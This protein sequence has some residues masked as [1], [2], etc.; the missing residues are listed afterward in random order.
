M[1]VCTCGSVSL[2]VC[3]SSADTEAKSLVMGYEHFALYLFIHLTALGLSCADLRCGMWNRPLTRDGVQIPPLYWERGF[4]ATKHSSVGKNPP[5]MLET[6]ARFL[7]Q[8][9]P[10]EKG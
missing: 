3:L 6:P 9:D 1:P 10:L 4:L 7:G 8:E 5:A 2:R